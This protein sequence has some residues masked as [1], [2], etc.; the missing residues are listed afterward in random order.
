[1]NLD[2][3]NAFVQENLFGGQ[4]AVHVWN[5]LGSQTAL[6][7][8]AVLWCEL[9]PSGSVGPHQ[10]QADAEVVICVSGEGQATVAGQTFALGPGALVH[11]PF[12]ATLS[13]ENT[14]SERPL[15]Y[16]I[17]KSTGAAG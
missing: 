11:L 8:S 15:C 3:Q 4:G 9:E 7:I 12:G 10:Q 16:L 17:V 14:S 6:P 13:L 1:M 5:L 2:K